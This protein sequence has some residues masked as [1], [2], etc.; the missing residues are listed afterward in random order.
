MGGFSKNEQTEIVRKALELEMTIQN[1]QEELLRKERERFKAVPP[2]PERKTAVPDYSNL[3][4]VNY[5]FSDYIQ[6][7]KNVKRDPL[8][9]FYGDK[10]YVMGL[11]GSG[12]FIF[13]AA[14]LTA[15]APSAYVLGIFSFAPLIG[16]AIYKSNK[17]K[18]YEQVLKEMNVRIT[19]T[20]LYIDEKMKAEMICQQKQ[21]EYDEQ[22]NLE[23][24][25]Y[26]T[27]ILV[28]YNNE[29]E[30]WT[31]ERDRMIQGLNE[32]IDN[33]T[34]E[35]NGLYLSTM[36]IPVQYRSIDALDYIYQL[37][38]TS[39]YEIKEAIDLY[40]REIQ[41]QLEMARI[42][43]MQIQNE[44][45]DQKNQSLMEQNE[46]LYQQNELQYRYN[47]I[48]ERHRKDDVRR[49]IETEYHR[50]QVRKNMKKR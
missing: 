1:A 19:Q 18:G 34:K 42:R 31:L 29:L 28:Q 36:I 24:Y 50:H 11:I 13:I 8:T 22:Y 40:D 35:L 20:P 23:K 43:E 45:A 15:V 5:Q 49:E 7:E 47:E 46:L 30:A 21:A 10:P 6:Y 4:K 14:I 32:K 44:L 33:S 48:A 37:M 12:I 17:K 39:G 16:A 2:E 41:R 9:I 25:N 26:D 38:S 27:V 3:P